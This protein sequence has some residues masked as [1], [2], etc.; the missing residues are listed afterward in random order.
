MKSEKNRLVSSSC[1]P[2]QL[3]LSCSTLSDY[4]HHYLPGLNL[5]TKELN[6]INSTEEI[7]KLYHEP[8]IGTRKPLPCL[9]LD[10]FASVTG[11]YDSIQDDFL[12]KRLGTCNG[13]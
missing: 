1:H 10:Q 12:E 9:V 7:S 2:V 4:R 5:V 6:V 8:R 13:P 3:P 11:K